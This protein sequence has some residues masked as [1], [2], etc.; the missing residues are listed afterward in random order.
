VSAVHGR[1]VHGTWLRHVAPP[2]EAG[3]SAACLPPP[4]LPRGEDQA[5]A[6]ATK[7]PLPSQGGRSPPW[8]VGD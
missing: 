3:G 5:E 8:G 1:A 4:P 6:A 7:W 2:R